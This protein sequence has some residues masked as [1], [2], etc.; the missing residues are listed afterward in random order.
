MKVK[1]YKITY[2]CQDGTVSESNRDVSETTLVDA[3]T[4][5]GYAPTPDRVSRVKEQ[6]IEKP[7]VIFLGDNDGFPSYAWIETPNMGEEGMLSALARINKKVG[8]KC[9]SV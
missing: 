3:L 8:K 9:N 4:E 1:L 2:T 5:C 7:Y 6:T